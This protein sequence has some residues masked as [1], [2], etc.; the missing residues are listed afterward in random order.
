MP[1][2]C[3]KVILVLKAGDSPPLE[4]ITEDT[5]VIAVIML[6]TGATG[7]CPAYGPFGISTLKKK[8]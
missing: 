3:W 1:A 8:G 6:L 7:Y 5:R 4:R 2:K